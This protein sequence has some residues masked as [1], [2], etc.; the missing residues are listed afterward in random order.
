VAEIA[1][2]AALVMATRIKLASPDSPCLGPPG[3]T[4]AEYEAE[5]GQQRLIGPTDGPRR[6]RPGRKVRVPL[7]IANDFGNEASRGLA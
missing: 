3:R 6:V 2:Q 7:E 1:S 5:S 4:V